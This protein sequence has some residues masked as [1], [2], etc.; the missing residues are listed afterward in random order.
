[1]HQI[2]DF[3]RTGSVERS[4]AD[5]LALARGAQE[6]AAAGPVT[7]TAPDTLPDWPLDGARME[8]VLV[9][10]LDNARQASPA[11]TP[12]E[13]SLSVSGGRLL[14]EV[15]DRG[16]GI[17]P[18]DEARVFE[19]FYTRRT[20]GTGLGLALAR[21][22]VEGHGGQIVAAGRPGGGTSFRIEIPRE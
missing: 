2:L 10:L 5:P 8:Q 7:C 14:I 17:E 9:N 3:A 22:I 6:R 4:P 21:R 16:E 1:M 12:V 11:G 15:A 18:G 19:P 13:L 20:Q